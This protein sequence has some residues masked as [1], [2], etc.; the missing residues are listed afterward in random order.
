MYLY[1][2]LYSRNVIDRLVSQLKFGRFCF[3][4]TLELAIWFAFTN[5][6]IRLELN[7]FTSNEHRL[8]A[9]FRINICK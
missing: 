6:T 5:V 7:H 9:Y 1:T 8:F 2:P 3:H 4:P